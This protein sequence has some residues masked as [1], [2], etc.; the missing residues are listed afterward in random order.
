MSSRS[1]RSPVDRFGRWIE[2]AI[3]SLLRRDLSGARLRLALT[4]LLLTAYWFGLATA[5]DYPRVVSTEWLNRVVFPVN[6]VIDFITSFAA[7]QLLRH[8]IPLVGGVYLALRLAVS[9]L[10][11]LQELG[12]QAIASRY[13]LAALFGIGHDRLR[14][15]QGDMQDLDQGSP[16]VKIGGPGYLDIMLGFAA[17]TEDRAGHPHVYGPQHR[18]FIRGFERLRDVVDLRDQLRQ[19]ASVR[20]MTADG[21]EVRA[22]DVQMVFRVYG[23]EQERNLQAPYPYTEEAVRRLVYA[24]PV[25][26]AGPRRWTGG[27]D[28]I[29][30]EQV[31]TFVG[32]LRLDQMLAMRPENATSSTSQPSFHISRRKLTERFHTEEATRQLREAGL[33]LIWV[34]VGTWEVGQGEG[35]ADIGGA[36]VEAWKMNQRLEASTSN[37]FAHRQKA[38]AKRSA[39]LQ[40][41]AAL[42]SSWS[43]SNTVHPDRAGL[44][45]RTFYDSL[46][47]QDPEALD[48]L[49]R[50]DPPAPKLALA[51]LR[52]LADL[53]RLEDRSD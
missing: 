19:V 22:R 43:A 28:R 17:V 25:S 46:M 49:E 1:D 26:D 4:G 51:H 16:L 12:S 6:V 35:E 42:V 5:A 37:T 15:S 40:P 27:L 18:R 45:L 21:I 8:L 24:Q 44:A 23:G 53:H 31:R 34:G 50:V 7:P 10:V 30:T 11:D 48:Q 33:E 13:L 14:I 29:V 47:R 3:Q 20:A 52:Q 2:P 9:F 41:I 32:S 39:I 38:V 36:L